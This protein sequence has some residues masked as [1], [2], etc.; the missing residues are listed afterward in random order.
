M[1]I[2]LYNAAVS[3]K[4][5]KLNLADF[6]IETPSNYGEVKA[7][8][9]GFEVDC[10]TIDSLKLPE[11]TLMKVDV[12]GHELNVLKGSK[13]TIERCRPHIFFEANDLEWLEPFKYLDKLEYNFY[14]IGC[15]SKPTRPTFI[16]TEENPFGASGVTNILAVPKEKEQPKVLIP[17]VYGEKFNDAANRYANYRW[18]F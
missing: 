17:V 9:E 4:K 7:D 15:R 13:K 11:V 8:S 3:N 12:E 14:W 1:P 6:D 16:E 10:I 2:T 5:G 18:L